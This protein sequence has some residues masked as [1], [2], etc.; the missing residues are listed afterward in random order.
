MDKGTDLLLPLLWSLLQVLALWRI[1]S[2]AGLHPV[3]ALLGF[4]PGLGL[5]LVLATLAFSPWSGK[6]NERGL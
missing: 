2:R 5:C 1:C 3:L 6:R 4:L